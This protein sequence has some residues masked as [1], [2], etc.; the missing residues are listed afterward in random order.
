MQW[1][2]PF[3][4]A[5]G[6]DLRHRFKLKVNRCFTSSWCLPRKLD[7]PR[8]GNRVADIKKHIVSWSSCSISA[9]QTKRKHNTS[10]TNRSFI[11]S[12]TSKH[13]G[14]VFTVTFL[15]TDTPGSN[16]LPLHTINSNRNCKRQRVILW[17]RLF[18]ETLLL[19][20]STFLRNAMK[21]LQGHR[22]S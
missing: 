12:L 2:F 8:C 16:F 3:K 9:V 14:A 15:S 21:T 19:K 1:E 22:D 17:H 5:A 6:K 13:T 4:Q 11:A 20:F 7:S 18:K 10:S